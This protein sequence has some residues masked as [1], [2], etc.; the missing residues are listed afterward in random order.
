M[1]IISRQQAISSG[2]SKYFTG[3]PCKNGHIAARYVYSC[4]CEMCIRVTSPH[5]APNPK[6]AQLQEH[7]ADMERMR[8]E[9]SQQRIA[10]AQ[11]KLAFSKQR[12]ALRARAK[13]TD[14]V[15]FRIMLH[16]A[17]VEFFKAVMLASA[18]TLDPSITL[19]DLT[20][21]KAPEVAGERAIYTF[22]TFQADID[23]LRTLEAEMTRDRR[24]RG[25]R[26]RHSYLA[27]D[28]APKSRRGRPQALR[29][30]CRERQPSTLRLTTY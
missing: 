3:E 29:S 12:A 14:L 8:L 18:I 24:T 20:T 5:P 9:Q 6:R 15:P 21:T 4:T 27:R 1:E 28:H 16:F 30:G 26:P 11:Q 22:R 7:R 19:D 10:I 23:S 2:F 13:R 25:G 17:D